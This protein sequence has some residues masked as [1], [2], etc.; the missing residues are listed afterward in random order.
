MPRTLRLVLRMTD[1]RS[2]PSGMVVP[3]ITYTTS[4]ES[5]NLWILRRIWLRTAPGVHRITHFVT[6]SAPQAQWT[7]N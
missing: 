3:S 1:G 6:G 7:T 2:T 5:T 4:E